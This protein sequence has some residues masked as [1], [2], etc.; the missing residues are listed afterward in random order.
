MP[1]HAP[2]MHLVD[3]IPEI[4]AGDFRGLPEGYFPFVTAINALAPTR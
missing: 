1:M 4:Q 2:A 3:P